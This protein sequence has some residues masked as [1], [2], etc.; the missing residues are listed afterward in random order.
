MRN[1]PDKICRENQNTHFVFS[2]IFFSEN[3]AVYKI[4]WQKY[5]RTLQATDDN[6]AHVRCMWILTARSTYSEYVK[7]IAFPWQ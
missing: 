2:N 1:V 5:C 4:M 3:R 6:M 7:F